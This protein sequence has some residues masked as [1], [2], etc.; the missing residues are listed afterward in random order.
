MGATV[1]LPGG[2]SA[3]CSRRTSRSSRLSVAR[4]SLGEPVED[5]LRRHGHP[6]RYR[7]TPAEWPI[8]AYQTVFARDPGS[9]EMPSAARPF[10]AE[11]VAELRRSRRPVR[12]AHAPLRRLLARAGREPVPRA[13]PRAGATAR[14]VNAVRGCGGRVIAV[15]TTVVRALETVA[16]PTAA[17][18]PARATNLIV[19]PERGLRAVD[20]L[21]TGWHEPSRRT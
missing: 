15:G 17:F 4:L 21:I 12:A 13:L 5:Y 10:T 14:L 7:H 16:S 2:G 18:A 6:I 20:G 3:S 1:E 11:L 9:A 8:D 19:T